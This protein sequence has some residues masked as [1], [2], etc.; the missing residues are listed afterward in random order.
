MVQGKQQVLTGDPDGWTWD[1]FE[2]EVMRWAQLIY[3]K[4]R[5]WF[6]VQP[7]ER[8]FMA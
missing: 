1:E 6:V 5:D 8:H 3:A 4:L 2:R 7:I